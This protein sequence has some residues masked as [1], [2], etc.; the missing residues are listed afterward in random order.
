MTHARIPDFSVPLPAHRAVCVPKPL[1]AEA[2]AVATPRDL[3][4]PT[5]AVFFLALLP[6]GGALV[7]IAC[8]VQLGLL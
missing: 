3:T 6:A 1:Q 8:L 2:V 5:L 7:L 4:T